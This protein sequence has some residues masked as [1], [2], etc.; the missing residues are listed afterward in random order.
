MSAFVLLFDTVV[1][2]VTLYH[3]LGTWRLQKGLKSMQKRSL[4]RLVL[5]QGRF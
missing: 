3:M 1:I 5:Q 2:A 4:T